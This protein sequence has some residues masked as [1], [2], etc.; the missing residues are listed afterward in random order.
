MA[1]KIPMTP[2]GH[3]KLKE[4]LKRL[5]EVDR[6]ANVKAIE[7]ARG[8]G[9]LSEN[10]DYSAAKEKQSF[11]EGRIRDIEAKLAFADV[12]DPT[13]LS[14]ER[15]VF[16]ATVTI[17]DPDTSEKQTYRIVGE[18]E[19]DIKN[20]TI[21]VTAPVARAMIGREV[22]D[23]VRVKTPKGFRELEIVEVKFEA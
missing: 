18:D 5:K 17:E 2:A 8:H 3:A 20:G 11:I 1:E 7:V 13:R 4:E 19:A 16:G 21:S 9:D 12:I 23:T 10:A 6:P 15:V 14:G 22:G